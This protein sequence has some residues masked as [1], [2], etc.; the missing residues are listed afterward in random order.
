MLL[1]PGPARA[2]ELTP[3]EQAGK[4]IFLSGESPSGGPILVKLG[5]DGST[6]PAS[7]APCGSCHGPDGRGRPEGGVRPS[8]VVWSE[9]AKPYGHAHEGGRKH[10]P[11]T[12]ATLARAVRGGVDPAG[13]PLDVSMPRYAMTDEDLG[14]LT[15]YLRRLEED[16]DPGIGADTLRIGAILPTSGALADVGLPMRAVLGGWFE[17]LNRRGG[18]HGRKVELVVAGYDSDRADGLAAA[19]ELLREGGVFALVS[20]LYP[21]AELE[22]ASLVDAA[23]VPQVG[24]F[25]LFA[26]S[27]GV[28]DSWI[29][30]PTGGLREQARGLAVFAAR[31]PGMGA[32][33]FAVVHAPEAPYGDA[34]RAAAE[35]LRARGI[36]PPV[37][38][39]L[40]GARQ[41]LADRIRKGDLDAV[42]ILAAD[43]G[44]EELTG[45]LATSGRAP[46]VLASGTLAGRAAT[47]LAM[48][49]PGKVFLAFPSSPS[50]ESP[51]AARE[52]A[53]LREAAGGAGRSRSSQA[54]AVVDAT[55]LVEGLKRTG[56]ALSREKLVESLEA[57]HSFETGLSPPVTFGPDR[58][59]GAR[60]AYVVRVDP[61]SRRFEPVGG[62]IPLEQ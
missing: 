3:R 57:L 5:R 6:L 46:P 20:G 56:R 30:H 35:E 44:L 33:R 4:R 10:P 7:A 11:F 1:A 14:S 59:L 60:G 8:P 48:R 45:A 61:A 47:Q 36:P 12:E 38:L 54:S 19:R 32:R 9:L 27:D 29:F 22:V 13:N 25:S 2:L 50:D 37:V 18:V 26:L 49:H 41:G 15:A 16:L 40:P 52:L 17:A 55:V 43:A 58:R 51:A 21:G 42:L 23:R 39:P 53:R 34:A 31:E 28:T 24:P 62:W